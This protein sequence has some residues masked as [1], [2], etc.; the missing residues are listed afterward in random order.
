MPKRKDWKKIVE[1]RKYSTGALKRIGRENERENFSALQSRKR[2]GSN[3]KEQTALNLNHSIA[4]TRQTV[5]QR[6][7]MGTHHYNMR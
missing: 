2:L 6:D 3:K 5:K 1:T 4:Q 7:N